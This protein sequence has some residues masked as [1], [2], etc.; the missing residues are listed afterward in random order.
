MTKYVSLINLQLGSFVAGRLEH[1]S[2][3][4]N[5]KVDTL[6]VVATSLS[7]KETMLLPVY[8]QLESLIIT[9]RVNEIDETS[10][11]W[12]T[13]VA[14]YLSSEELPYNRVEAYKI[15]VQEARVIPQ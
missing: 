14:H 7:I 2:I 6:A 15:Q 10:P 11:S 12:I 3:R 13:L 8:Y 4:S 1:V 5:E 9:N